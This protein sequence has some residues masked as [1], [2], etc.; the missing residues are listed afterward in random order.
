MSADP[1]QRVIHALSR[2]PS[3]GEKTAARLT[4]FM[5]NRSP[6][7][8]QELS[9]ALGSLHAS[10]RFCSECEHLTARDPCH[11]CSNLKRKKNLIC[12][13]EDVSS[14]MAIERTGVFEGRYHVLHGLISPL[15]GIGPDDL[16]LNTLLERIGRLRSSDPEQNV[17]VIVALQSGVNGN[18][19]SLFLQHVLKPLGVKL[20]KIASGVPVGTNLQYADQVSLAEALSDRRPL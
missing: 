16:K 15:D 14:L 20:S 9:E 2:L 13:V 12:V 18:A 7:L 1:I 3:I 8:T 17:E 19:T 10:V 6:E 11:I 4:F 5:L